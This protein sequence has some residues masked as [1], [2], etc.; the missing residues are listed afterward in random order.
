MKSLIIAEKPSV[1]TDLSKVLGKFKKVGNFYENNEYVIGS[2]IGHVV[3]LFMP[4]D[5]DRKLKWWSLKTLPILPKKFE[6]KPIERTKDRFAALKKAMTRKDVDCVINACDA[7]REGELIFTYIYA[8]A[9]CKKPIKRLWMMSMTTQAIKDAFT[10]LRD[11][12]EMVPL[13]EAA[14]CRSES[15]WLIGINGTRAITSCMFGSRSGQIATIGRVQTPTLT[16]VHEREQVIRNFKPKAYWKLVGKFGVDAGEYEGTYQRKDFKKKDGDEHDR[17]DRIW[18]KAEVKKILKACKSADKADV[19]EKKKRSKQS[20][21]MLYDLTSLQREANSRFGMPAGITLK[22]VQSLYEKHK[23]LTYPRTDSKTLPEDYGPTCKKVLSKL[24]G[25]FDT[26]TEEV[27]AKNWVNTS[28]KRIFNNKKI[29]D[30]FAIIPTDSSPKKLSDDEYKIYYMVVRRFVAAFYP[31]AE[32]DVT[33]RMSKSGE[34]EFKTEGKVLAAPGWMV[35]YGKNHQ[36]EG[37]IPALSKKDGDPTKA[38]VISVEMNEE[39]TKPP[40]RYS[41]ATLLAAMEHAGK[42]VDDEELADA[43]KERG[44]GTPATR[45]Q[46]IEHLIREKYI[47]REQRELIPTINAENLIKFLHLVNV[48]YLTSPTMTAEWEHSLK[49]IENGE[50]TREEFMRGIKEVTK[51]IVNKTKDFNEEKSETQIISPTDNL[52]MMENFRCYKSQDGQMTIYKTMGKRKLSVEEVNELV[53]KG[54]I[55]PLDNFISKAGKPFSAMLRLDENHKA[56]FVFENERDSGE[57]IENMEQYEVVC[58]C[59]LSK[60]GICTRKE[61]KVYATPNAYQCKHHGEDRSKCTFRVSRTLLD[62]SIPEDQLA[63]LANEGKT[64]VLDKFK[65]KKTKRFFSACLI[66]KKDGGIGFEFEI[67]AKNAH[68]K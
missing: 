19:T 10:Q 47:L 28:N 44:L 8:L 26:Y 16:L 4:D 67:K 43:M 32:F 58:E 14:K 23:M 38:K 36:A 7:G 33:T 53:T 17:V 57:K 50:M 41:E 9:E 56:K 62:R 6:L 29:S 25:E 21:P 3:E 66:L 42:F 59:P 22:I 27:L 2:A 63:K 61:G 31:A 40:P 49:K 35:V 11:S 24:S 1:A 15:D 18:D 20:P 64:D 13:F 46:I 54:S 37:Q 5:I 68:K 12:K 51:N 45:A 34:H 65:S 48:D 55:G 52:P 39:T 30:H 60:K